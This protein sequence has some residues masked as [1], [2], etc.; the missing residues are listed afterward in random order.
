MRPIRE[1]AADFR[2]RD[3]WL[4]DWN[5]PREAWRERG[6]AEIAFTL[7]GLG[8]APE[9]LT[10]VLALADQVTPTY[11]PA[12]LTADGYRLGVGRPDRTGGEPLGLYRG[13]AIVAW[14]ISLA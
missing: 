7:E 3:A 14:T 11:C 12:G 10:R 6:P 1:A 9:V 5:Q 2:R 4:T 8:A 13:L